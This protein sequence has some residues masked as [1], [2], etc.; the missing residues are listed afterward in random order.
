MTTTDPEMAL[1]CPPCGA[2]LAYVRADGETHIYRCR[3]HGA[4]LVRP[5]S[6]ITRRSK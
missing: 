1:N 5:D 2:A 6:R 3:R 4:F